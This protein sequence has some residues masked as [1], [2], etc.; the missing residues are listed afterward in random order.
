MN[1]SVGGHIDLLV[2]ENYNVIEFDLGC[3]LIND[4]IPNVGVYGD[5]E[6]YAY[7]EANDESNKMLMT[8]LLE[9]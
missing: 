3:G 6:D 7:E 2:R 1:Q 4:Q 5:D 8:N 9:T